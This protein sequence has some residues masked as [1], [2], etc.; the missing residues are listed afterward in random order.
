MAELSGI[1]LKMLLLSTGELLFVTVFYFIID[2]TGITEESVN[3]FIDHYQ[4]MFLFVLLVGWGV[5]RLRR[6][7][8]NNKIA[9]E[10]LKNLKK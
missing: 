3:G 8:I 9:K 10:N 2:Q 4:K 6:E 5:L 1:W 7:W